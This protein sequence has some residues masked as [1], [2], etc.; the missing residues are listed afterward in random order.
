METHTEANI[1]SPSCQWA[2]SSSHDNPLL[3]P[4]GY[5]TWLLVGT[6]SSSR[7]GRCALLP[8]KF[9]SWVLFS[10]SWAMKLISY[11][12]SSDY[13]IIIFK[14]RWQ[15]GVTSNTSRDHLVE[16]AGILRFI[17][18]LRLQWRQGLISNIYNGSGKG[19]CQGVYNAFAN[20]VLQCL[21]VFQTIS[22]W[23]D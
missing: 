12:L 9:V 21:I 11:V 2:S 4:T 6:S 3:Q 16:G 18:I 8:V 19:W 22:D 5:I 13:F 7:H 1:N 15:I 20:P 10:T 14:W 23:M 17:R